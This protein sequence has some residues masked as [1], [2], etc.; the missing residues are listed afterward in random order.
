[1]GVKDRSA[2]VRAF[3][4]EG[5]VDAAERTFFSKGF[6]ATTMDD[7]AREAEYTKKTLYSYFAGKDELY[8]AIMLRGFE[9]LNTLFDRVL[10][11]RR[12]AKGFDQLDSLGRAYITFIEEHA[13][14]FEAIALYESRREE[15]GVSSALAGAMAAEGNRSSELLI[16]CVRRGI[17]DG[18]ISGELDPVRTAFALYAWMLGMGNLIL[19]KRKY[20]EGSFNCKAEDIIG[21]MFRLIPHGISP[22]EES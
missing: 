9:T 4:R 17:E 22:Y 14:Y 5:I 6:A 15:S 11:E 18:S 3:R 1:M 13:E 12:E 2:K 16:G 21:E 10:L 20:I 8:D 7:V 19:R